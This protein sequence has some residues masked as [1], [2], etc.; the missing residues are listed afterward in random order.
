M[1]NQ[2][3]K[4]SGYRDLTQAEI[5][6]MNRIKAKAAEVGVLVAELFAMQAK[7]ADTLCSQ[8]NRPDFTEL[9]DAHVDARRWSRIAKDQL[10]Q[11][12]MA[13]VRAVARPTTF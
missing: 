10:Q 3:K 5:D 7:E 12:F 11:G 8:T 13:L 9:M 6:L 1:D 4:I 2:H